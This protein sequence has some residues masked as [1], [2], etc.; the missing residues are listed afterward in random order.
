M[1]SIWGEDNDLINAVFVEVGKGDGTSTITK[2]KGWTGDLTYEAEVI[3]T[4][5]LVEL[6][7]PWD[8]YCKLI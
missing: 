6:D 5:C 2:F 7:N 4:K 3:V 8:G 1:P